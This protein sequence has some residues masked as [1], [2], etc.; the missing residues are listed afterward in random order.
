MSGP[1]TVSTALAFALSA[2][3]DASPPRGDAGGGRVPI[4]PCDLSEPG[5][6]LFEDMTA[7]SGVSFVAHTYDSHAR[8]GVA[9][10]DVDGSGLPDLVTV[11]ET[12]GLR[13]F[14]NEG[15]FSFADET[16]DAGLDSSVAATAAAL[17]D[18]DGDGDLDL[19]AVGT[20]AHRIYENDGAGAFGDVS[21][22]SSLGPGRA[23]SFVLPVDLD[24]DGLLDLVVGVGTPGG[25]NAVLHNTGGLAFGDVSTDAGISGG[26]V[27]WAA[28]ALDFDGDGDLDVYMARDA[29]V[30]DF[31]GELPP[32]AG[33]GERDHLYRND[34]AGGRIVLTDVTAEVGMAEPHSS[35]GGVVADFDL[36]GAFD[37]FIPNYGANKLYRGGLG[38]TYEE[39][40]TELG[41][42]AV[43]DRQLACATSDEARCLMVSWGT[44]LADFNLDGADE[45]LM[46]NGLYEPQS[47]VLLRR[48][49]ANGPFDVPG[50]GLGC[51]TGR[52]LVAADLD[53]DG[54]LDLVA[55]EFDGP[56]RLFRTRVPEARRW[57]IVRL[58]GSDN[59]PDGA[60]AIVTAI[61]PDGRR[62]RRAVGAGGIAHAAG[63]SEAHFG[64]GAVDIVDL[65][66]AWPGRPT[67]YIEDVTVDVVLVIAEP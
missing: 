37:L 16:A 43:H 29:G 42:A 59:A 5:D 10:G 9:V 57:L 24:R 7:A 49:G 50:D 3:G 36:D 47:S 58:S 17:A 11:S 4:M 34:S 14:R 15:A 39:A 56:L 13:L 26:G 1:R 41:V 33:G 52:A 6:P 66:V 8:A 61:L 46:I 22:R 18:L 19:I 45:L 64:L 23:A 67:Q 48:D 35:M 60:G 30:L 21:A 54:D 53:G 51:F 63:P 25:A 28:S 31:G 38:G 27:V 55:T 12:G 32:G 40:A 20:D 2:C 65:E 44:V 62:I